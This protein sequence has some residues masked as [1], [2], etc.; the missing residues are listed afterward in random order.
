VWDWYGRTALYI[1]ID[2][3]NGGSSGGGIRVPID[4]SRSARFSSRDIIRIL[5]DAN[6]DPNA[7]LRMH[8]PTRG[9]YTGRFSEPLLDT[10]ATPL[11]RAV[12][13]NDMETIQA[14]LAKGASPNINAM[15]VTP[16]LVA[17]GVGGGGG[18]RGGGGARGGG[19]GFAL[20]DLLI[21]RGADVNVQVTGTKTYSMRISF[22]T[23]LR[24][25]PTRRSPI[26]TA[27]KRSTWSAAPRPLPPLRAVAEV[28]VVLKREVPM[29]LRF[30]PCWRTRRRRSRT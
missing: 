7:E 26:A 19:E 14:L 27:A 5:L 15:G 23:C 28:G 8:R 3:K 13:G 4:P 24:K 12:M 22:V 17:A 10:G 9:G 16:F 25:A 2:R 6:V 29:R 21:T 18:Q 30:V 1:A 20:L 11:L